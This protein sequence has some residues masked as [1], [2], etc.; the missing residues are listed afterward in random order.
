M[1]LDVNTV[2]PWLN[3]NSEYKNRQESYSPLNSTIGLCARRGEQG[4]GE[5]FLN[6]NR[7]SRAVWN[8][9]ADFKAAFNQND[10]DFCCLVFG[11]GAEKA[12]CAFYA[13][14]SFLIESTLPVTLFAESSDKL[15]NFWKT[16][17]AENTLLYHGYCLNCDDRDPDETVPIGVGVS[18]KSGV[19]EST[20]KKLHILPQNGRVTVA[21]AMEALEI[22]EERLKKNVQSAPENTKEAKALCEAWVRDMLRNLELD[23]PTEAEAKLA[24]RAIGGLL[25]NLAEAQGNLRG[26]ISS[27][28]NRGTYPT[29]FLWDSC[30]QNLAYEVMNP[31]LAADSL[32]CLAATQRADGKYG[33]FN[34]STWS[35]PHYTQPALV[36]WAALRLARQT[37]DKEF[38][39]TMLPS[40]EKNNCWWL[41]Q[42]M[43][44]CGLICCPHG[45]ETGQDDSPRFDNGTTISVDMNSYLLSQMRAAAELARMI[46]EPEKADYWQQKADAFAALMVELLYD[47]EAGLF[48]DLMPDTME[49]VTIVASSDLLPLWAGVPLSKEKTDGMIRKYLLNPAHLFGNIPFPSIGYGE[50]CYEAASWWRGPTWLPIARL[51]LEL[52]INHGY[53]E[54]AREASLRLYRMLVKDG[55]LHELFNSQT[56]EGLGS[57]EQGWSCA[58]FI[59]LCRDLYGKNKD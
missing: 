46:D 50:S 48:F 35:R 1:K 54:Q 38:I 2:L 7:A 51:M 34:C 10:S 15:V 12:E 21:F 49:R 33:Q 9:L 58:I 52:L 18:V 16:E 55:E 37:G 42:R 47:E 8:R 14:D 4:I 22:D 29:H 26:Y 43:T 41:S 13:A 53:E 17:E 59:R 5:L 32:L 45:L 56:G 23:L 30:F 36:G 11:E 27:F 6:Y 28:P 44:P 25:Q 57:V 40:L 3:R 24:A 39:R 31:A 20:E 19:M